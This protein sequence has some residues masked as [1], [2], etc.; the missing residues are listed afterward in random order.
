MQITTKTEYAVRALCALALQ[1]NA[2]PISVREICLRH[3]LP[4]KYIEQ[5]FR[6]LKK[7][8]IIK[9][10][11][12]AKG[13]YI[14]A[15][16]PRNISLHFIMQAVDESHHSVKCDRLSDSSSTYCIGNPCGF[17]SF[18]NKIA[19]HLSA[20]FQTLNLQHI[21]DELNKGAQNDL[22]E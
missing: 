8:G 17:H 12:G 10:Q 16:S 14:L 7:Q 13:G 6:K 21:L 18:W 4:Q 22:P 1:D 15:T 3:N 2:Q 9:S 5:L 20:Y 11:H 19:E